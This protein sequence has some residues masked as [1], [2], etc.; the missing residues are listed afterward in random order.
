M[1]RKAD[2]L[3]TGIASFAALEAAAQRAA[4]GK[5]RKP[6]VAAFL[7]RLGFAA[8]PSTTPDE[9][10]R[11]SL[12]KFEEVASRSKI[13][14]VFCAQAFQRPRPARQLPPAPGQKRHQYRPVLVHPRALPVMRQ[15]SRQE[16]MT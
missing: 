4:R 1:R 6:G 15:D 7:A 12:R 14:V 5:R 2:G 3:F 11:Q 10:L 16:T 9:D 8:P 13:A